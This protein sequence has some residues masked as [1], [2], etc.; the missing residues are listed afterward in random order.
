MRVKRNLLAQSTVGAIFLNR[1][2]GLTD[3]NRSAGLDAGFLFGKH[4]TL[5]GLL[6]RTSTPGVHGKDA[7]GV[8]DFIWKSDRF[9]YGLQYADIGKNF[10]AEMGFIV[11]TDVR[12]TK[13]KASWTPRPHWPGVRQLAFNA[14]VENYDN[15]AGRL[16]SRTSTGSWQMTRHDTST[17]VVSVIRDFDTLDVPFAVAGTRIPVG[18][19][20]WTSGSLSYTSNQSRRVSGS[21]TLEAGEYYDGH[22]Q[23]ARVSLNL[24]VG[25]TLLFEPNVTRNHVTLPG[26]PDFTSHVVNLRVSQSFSPALFLKGFAQYNDE[27]KTASFNFLFWYIYRPGSDLYVVYNQGWDTE[28]PGGPRARVRGRSLAIKTT[29]WWAR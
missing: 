28:V 18:A 4:T 1:E 14:N 6:A 5:T 20:D 3:Y 16:E 22:R 27:R 9:T 24:Q 25:R 23:T 8:A 10:N 13:A 26:R 2:G 15:H 7:A 19:Y 11:R 17:L 29:Y 21:T 12:S